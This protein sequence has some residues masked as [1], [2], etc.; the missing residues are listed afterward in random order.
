MI[1]GIGVDIVDINDFTESFNK[2]KRFKSLVFTES[3]ILYC[4]NKLNKYQHYAARFAGKEAMMKA[5]CTGWGK[6]IGFR[7]IEI[8]NCDNGYPILRCNGKVKEILIERNI[9][10]CLISLSHIENN[11]IAFI[12]LERI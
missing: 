5:I 3:E 1:I 9:S 11:A 4:E 8:I 2:S 7:Q 6:G 10:N 12:L